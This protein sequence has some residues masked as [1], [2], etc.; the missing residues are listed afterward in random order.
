[1]IAAA[2]AQGVRKLVYTSSAGVV[3]SGYDIVDGDETL[4]YPSKHLDAYTE[5]KALA[6]QEVLSANGRGGLVTVAIRP[7]GVFGYG[8]SIVTLHLYHRLMLGL[9]LAIVKPSLEHI[10]H[11]N[12]G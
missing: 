1:M 12:V 5:S 4:A 8:L 11:S 9:D 3:F 10:M 7:G 6:E 2:I